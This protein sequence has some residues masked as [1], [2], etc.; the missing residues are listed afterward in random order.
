MI[1]H[2]PQTKK[3][4]AH[5]SPPLYSFWFPTSSA[6]MFTQLYR[7]C[8]VKTRMCG[9]YTN[10]RDIAWRN[11]NKVLKFATYK[12]VEVDLNKD[13]VPY[14]QFCTLA[15][16]T[17]TIAVAAQLC[18]TSTRRLRRRTFNRLSVQDWSA[19]MSVGGLKKQY[20]KVTQ[21]CLQEDWRSNTTK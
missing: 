11:P 6:D 13:W 21:V 19:R 18:W 12:S 2:S 3:Q 8:D 4:Q 9:T 7:R 5:F 17:N 14:H 10:S 16:E 1:L 20:N 15:C